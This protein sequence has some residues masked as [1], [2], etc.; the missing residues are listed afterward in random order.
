MFSDR[1]S[2]SSAVALAVG[3]STRE[4]QTAHSESR[5][6]TARLRARVNVVADGL[7]GVAHVLE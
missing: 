4:R 2:P 5:G 3:M 7:V 1:E 6:W